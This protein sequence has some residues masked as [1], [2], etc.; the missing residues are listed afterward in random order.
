[1]TKI[2]PSVSPE[3]ALHR[4]IGLFGIDEAAD[5]IGKTTATLYAFGDADKE[6]NISLRDAMKLDL[7]CLAT[8]NETPFMTMQRRAVE[9]I[10]F[11]ACPDVTDALLNL[12]SGAGRLNDVVRAS[13]QPHS[14]GGKR[15]TETEKKR[16]YDITDEVLTLVHQIRASTH[17]GV[18]ATGKTSCKSSTI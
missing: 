2:R 12:H 10:G 7:A 9:A 18:K 14:P 5:L 15:M 16:I 3:G 6:K 4:V 11:R 17:D 8:F 13:M 1:M